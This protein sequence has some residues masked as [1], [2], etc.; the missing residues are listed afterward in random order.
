MRGVCDVLERAVAF[1]EKK[2]IFG[3]VV[4]DIQVRPAIAVHVHP[5]SDEPASR[6]I[7]DTSLH[8]AFRERA[9]AIVVKEELPLAGE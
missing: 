7:V 5:R 8:R 1:V 6:G 4:S 3:D 2:K 9:V